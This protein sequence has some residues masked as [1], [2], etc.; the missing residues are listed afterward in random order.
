MRAGIDAGKSEAPPRFAALFSVGPSK[1]KDLRIRH[2]RRFSLLIGKFR[3]HLKNLQEHLAR[4]LAG[5]R[6]LV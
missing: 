1:G 2:Q 4:E 6:V 3:R 5:L